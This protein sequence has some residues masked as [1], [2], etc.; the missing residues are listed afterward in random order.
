ME[1]G[2]ATEIVDGYR[3]VQS[4]VRAT[5]WRDEDRWLLPAAALSAVVLHI[6]LVGAALEQW[7]DQ[8]G[9]PI[10]RVLVADLVVEPPTQPPEAPSTQPAEAGPEPAAPQPTDLRQSGGD[11]DLASGSA[12]LEPKPQA[13]AP[14]ELTFD[15]VQGP[16][17]ELVAAPPAPAPSQQPPS[18][19][20]ASIPSYYPTDGKGGGDR[21]LNEVR[22]M[23]LEQ[24]NYALRRSG[25]AHY[26]ILIDRFGNLLSAKLLFTSGVGVV[27]VVGMGMIRNAAPFPPVPKDMKGDQISLSIR[28]SLGPKDSH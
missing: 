25:T 2:S 13:S 8:K 20:T 4:D 21:Y 9:P 14:P 23:I 12:E 3:L 26:Q 7:P 1:A 27:D 22:D 16:Q 17:P 24:R 6:A 18:E 5:R 28:L 10:E 11:P 19:V 15:P